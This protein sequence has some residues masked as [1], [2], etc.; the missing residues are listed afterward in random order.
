VRL[1]LD[2]Y[3]EG[4]DLPAPGLFR[5]GFGLADSAATAEELDLGPSL[6]MGVLSSSEEDE[7]PSGTM[8]VRRGARA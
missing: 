6:D 7:P 1:S 8:R 4:D 2:T 5:P 3:D